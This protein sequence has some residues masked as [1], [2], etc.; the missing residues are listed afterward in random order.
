MPEALDGP[1]PVVLAVLC[2][3]PLAAVLGGSLPVALGGIM[4]LTLA[5][6][7]LLR[8][9]GGCEEVKPVKGCVKGDAMAPNA[10]EPICEEGV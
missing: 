10:G 5:A 4:P 1:I 8:A 9:E 2:S 7:C 3:I 6:P